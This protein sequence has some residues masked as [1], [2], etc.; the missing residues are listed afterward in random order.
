MTRAFLLVGC[1]DGLGI[2]N[3]FL[4]PAAVVLLVVVVWG[5]RAKPGEGAVEGLELVLV[6]VVVV[7]FDG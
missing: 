5:E 7:A 6:A 1:M 2:A 3:F 4:Q